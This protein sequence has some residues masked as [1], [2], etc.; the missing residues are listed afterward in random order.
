MKLIKDWL[1]NGAIAVWASN[2]GYY[3]GWNIDNWQWWC[4]VT[5]LYTLILFSLNCVYQYFDERKAQ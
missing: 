4:V 5:P 2:L 1:V 3:L